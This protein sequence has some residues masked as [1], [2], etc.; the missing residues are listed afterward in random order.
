M[1][2]NEPLFKSLKEISKI[3]GFKDIRTV[4]KW[5]IK[6]EVQILNDP[7]NRWNYVITA[8][9]EAARYRQMIHYLKRK[10]GNKWTDAFKAYLQVDSLFRAAHSK[11]DISDSHL[12]EQM[13]QH[14]R[15]FLSSLTQSTPEL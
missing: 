15:K 6:N 11:I 12:T 3:L 9:F 2:E 8:E 13:G 7:G 4:R 10:Y 1:P 14:E 5:C